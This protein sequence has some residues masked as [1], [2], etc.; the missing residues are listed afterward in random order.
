MT[1]SGGILLFLLDFFA[2]SCYD[3]QNTMKRMDTI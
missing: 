2:E 3:N 1:I